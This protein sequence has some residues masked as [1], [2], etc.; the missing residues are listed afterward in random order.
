MVINEGDTI[1]HSQ[2]ILSYFL[3]RQVS[4]RLN[5]DGNDSEF[6]EGAEE[7]AA[8][9]ASSKSSKSSKSSAS[10]TSKTPTVKSEGEEE[11]GVKSVPPD[12]EVDYEALDNENTEPVIVEDD[13]EEQQEP[14]KQPEE[15]VEEAEETQED[16]PKNAEETQAA[17]P[18]EAEESV[19]EPLLAEQPGEAAEQPSSPAKGNS[20][21]DVAL[22]IKPGDLVLEDVAS[23]L[24][25][26]I[27]NHK[28]GTVPPTNQSFYFY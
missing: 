10:H 13:E 22:K 7:R 2:L 24:S 21:P 14:E 4:K 28:I 1:Y 16:Q 6:D 20:A 12:T 11:E 18:E 3:N 8:S 17:Q 25:V 9:A 23:I 27:N 26:D 5:V 15:V 19:P